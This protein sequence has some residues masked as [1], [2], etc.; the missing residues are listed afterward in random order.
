MKTIFIGPSGF[1]LDKKLLEGWN[2]R[3]PCKQSDIIKLI[4]NNSLEEILLV[5]GY[6]KSIPSP[7][8]KEIL[9]ALEKGISVTGVSSLGALR[10]SELNK[11]G[12]KGFGWVYE[13][14]RDNEPLDDSLVALIHKSS[15]EQY[16]PITFAKIEI[17]YF[18][19]KM[20]E[21]NLIKN[22]NVKD[23]TKKISHTLFEK[24]NLKYFELLLR[25]N[26]VE[27][28]KKLIQTHYE[29]IKIKDIKNYLI[30]TYPNISTKKIKTEKTPYIYRQKVL[31]LKTFNESNDF[32]DINTTFQNYV[33]FKFPY[34]YERYLIDAHIYLLLNSISNKYKFIDKHKKNKFPDF[35][36]LIGEVYLFN[37]TII[38]CDNLNLIYFECKDNLK[39][40][41]SL[42]LNLNN[43]YSLSYS[44]NN[45]IIEI[46]NNFVL[47]K[48]I[49][50][51]GNING[52]FIANKKS[53]FLLL[54]NLCLLNRLL[55]NPKRNII[56]LEKE[57]KE[58]LINSP[59]Y[60]IYLFELFHFFSKSHALTNYHGSSIIQTLAK[61]NGDIVSSYKKFIKDKE[62]NK[63]HRLYCET[64]NNLQ[65]IIILRSLTERNKNLLIPFRRPTCLSTHFIYFDNLIR[66]TESI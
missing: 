48:L 44:L 31:D 33:F 55:F 56:N 49:S 54:L 58:N 62:S 51:K 3:P 57:N 66:F 6:Y 12:L 52:N 1:G 18:I 19:E 29:S 16:E 45:K 39:N 10:A 63:P 60:I 38:K 36:N 65:R 22:I 46:A 32:S 34:L 30:S 50:S 53:N 61:K 41:E 24:F 11:Y 37:E 8:H 35:Y 40:L 26:G 25:E 21:I 47:P 23:L 43:I 2:I 64:T 4:E 7:W 15:E 42:V 28:P 5:D 13:F 17:I 59:K 14:I 27:N 20:I 9:L